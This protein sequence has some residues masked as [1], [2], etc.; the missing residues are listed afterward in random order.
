MNPARLSAALTSSPSFGLNLSSLY[1]SLISLLLNFSFFPFI[2]T[3]LSNSSSVNI[4]ISGCHSSGISPYTSFSICSF[5]YPFIRSLTRDDKKAVELFTQSAAQGYA[6]AQYRL[7]LLL[8]HLF[9]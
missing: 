2:V 4:L 5:S 3:T 8:T 9:L 6:P 1:V 7:A